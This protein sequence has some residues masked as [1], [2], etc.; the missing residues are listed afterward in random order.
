MSAENLKEQRSFWVR[1]YCQ[2]LGETGFL[3]TPVKSPTEYASYIA[4]LLLDKVKEKSPLTPPIMLSSVA[5]DFS[6]QPEPN[7]ENMDDAYGMINFDKTKGEFI[8]TLRGDCMQ[9]EAQHPWQESHLNLMGRFTYT[10]EIAHRF[11][12]IPKGDGNFIN[13]RNETLKKVEDPNPFYHLRELEEM[14]C[15]LIARRTL[16]P[17]PLV[18]EL[19]R[20]YLPDE[21]D[22]PLPSIGE[23]ILEA[24]QKF[25]APPSS[26]ILAF[27][28]AVHK[29][30]LKVDPDLFMLY[31]RYTMRKKYE[32]GVI[33]VKILV[34]PF[35]G[36]NTGLKEPFLYMSYPDKLGSRFYRGTAVRI[37][38]HDWDKCQ[39]EIDTPIIID[40]DGKKLVLQMEGFWQS[41]AD[42]ET[43]RT[44][45]I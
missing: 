45:L 26:A 21:K 34:G 38:C 20:T 36:N 33:R 19:A 43:L 8:I 35:T 18:A 1:R 37:F 7:I 42:D 2:K 11:L 30:Y 6:I 40:K 13:A 4:D 23:L 22:L 10:H 32:M 24:S 27:R 31:L 14:S 9:D 39:G 28:E 15:N 16:I 12:F 25:L 5:G 29:N 17:S 44:A 3:D 41:I